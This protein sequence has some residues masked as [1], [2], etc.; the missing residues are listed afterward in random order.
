MLVEFENQFIVAH[1]FPRIYFTVLTACFIFMGFSG[2]VMLIPVE[3]SSFA[4]DPKRCMPLVILREIGGARSIAVPI[5]H[6]AANAIAMNALQVQFD[7]PFAIDLVK[8]AIEQ[9]GAAL[10]R[11]VIG[12]VADEVFT[13]SIVISAASSLKVIDCRPCDAI[14]LAVKC[15]AP[16]FVRDAVFLKLESDDGLSEAERLRERVRSVDA[17]EFGKYVLE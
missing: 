15:G 13:A 6:S 1:P 16:I 11:V 10:Y 3:I 2:N 9:L 17:T 7:K 4:I 5:E 12:D 14:T 8:I